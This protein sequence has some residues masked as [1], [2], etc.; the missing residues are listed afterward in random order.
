MDA[1]YFKRSSTESWS[2]YSPTTSQPTSIDTYIT[3]QVPQ[4][5]VIFDMSRG[6]MHCD[7]M[8][9]I[10]VTGENAEKLKGGEK[11]VVKEGEKILGLLDAGTLFDI[12]QIQI[13]GITVYHETFNQTQCRLRSL[14]T[15]DDWCLAQPQTYFNPVTTKITETNQLTCKKIQLPSSF[16]TNDI[17]YV[18]KHLS[19]PLPSIFPCFENMNVW[20]SFCVNDTLILTLSVSQL[21]KYMVLLKEEDPTSTGIYNSVYTITTGTDYSCKYSFP[22]DDTE[23]MDDTPSL[24]VEISFDFKNAVIDK[25]TIHVPYHSPEH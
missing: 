5:N 3:F 1:G 23:T 13:G 10:K 17:I 22:N 25:S 15:S 16:S 21:D 11:L 18:T 4:T 14:N 20:P 7:L 12:V 24:D 9:P 2:N 6:V 8:I 19:V